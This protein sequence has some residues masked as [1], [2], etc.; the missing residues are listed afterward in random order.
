MDKENLQGPVAK[1]RRFATAKKNEDILK[2]QNSAIPVK[3]EQATSWA[4]NAWQQWAMQ[5]D[6][7]TPEE[8]IQLLSNHLEEMPAE[9]L[10]FWL[11]RFILEVRKKNTDEYPPNSLYQM[12]CGIQRHLQ[13]ISTTDFFL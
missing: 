6:R 5:R 1:K 10:K 7:D 2:A 13:K 9:A 3:T 4:I 11:P 8:T 12:V